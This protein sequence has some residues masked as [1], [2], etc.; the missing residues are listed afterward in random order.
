MHASTLTPTLC[1]A[2]ARQLSQLDLKKRAYLGPTSL[3]A[4]LS[5]VMV[6]VGKVSVVM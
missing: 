3:C 2:L 6:N 1:R 4:H 5:V